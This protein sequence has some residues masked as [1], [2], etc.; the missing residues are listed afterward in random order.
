[1][2][3]NYTPL[4]KLVNTIKV[5]EVLNKNIDWHLLLNDSLFKDILIARYCRNKSPNFPLRI[6]NIYCYPEDI[7]RLET[8]LKL[9][10]LTKKLNIPLR[11]SDL[12]KISSRPKCSCTPYYG[13]YY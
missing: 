11:V 5:V 3:L 2:N 6:H 7:E 9:H 13:L 1:M 4:N 10:P 12:I 8:S